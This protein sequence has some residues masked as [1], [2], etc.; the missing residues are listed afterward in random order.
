MKLYPDWVDE[1]YM[2]ALPWLNILTSDPETMPVR[3]HNRLM[4]EGMRELK[5]ELKMEIMEE[6]LR[7]Q[8]FK[9]PE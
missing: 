1:I 2:D 3:E 8:S 7:S 5:R 6:L 9:L 4:A